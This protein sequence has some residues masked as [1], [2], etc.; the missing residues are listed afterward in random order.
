MVLP[1]RI[2]FSRVSA[3]AANR[4]AAGING[5]SSISN[6]IE[7]HF[8]EKRVRDNACSGGHNDAFVLDKRL[9]I[10]AFF[11]GK[12]SRIFFV[13]PSRVTSSFNS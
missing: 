11:C 4:Y 10:G 2:I 7:S 12:S 1:L 8:V 5:A 6:D 9:S 3:A 13:P